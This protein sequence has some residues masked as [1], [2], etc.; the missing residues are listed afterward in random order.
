MLLCDA[1]YTHMAEGID[2]VLRTFARDWRGKKVLVKPNLLGAFLPERGV[3]TH[4]AVVNAVVKWLGAHGAKIVVGDNPGHIGY[5]INETVAL[6]S[7]I[8]A[9][10]DGCF[11]NI[12]TNPVKVSIGKAEVLVSKEVI[13]SDVYVSLPK[14][15]THI[16]T[17]FTGAIKN[18]YGL[19][20]GREKSRLHQMFPQL[21]DFA[22][23]V[24]AVYS[25]RPPD[26]VIMDAVVG[27]EGNGPNSKRL[28]DI[29]KIIG[30][31][32][33]VALDAVMCSMMGLNPKDQPL[34]QAAH[35]LGLGPILL[36]EINVKGDFNQIM[37]FQ[38]PVTYRSANT[39]QQY[40]VDRLLGRGRI[41]FDYNKC[42]SCG[43][44]IKACPQQ[45]IRLIESSR[46]L[47]PVVDNSRC[48][49]CFC[50][51]EMC[52]YNAVSFTGLFAALQ[53]VHNALARTW[54]FKYIIR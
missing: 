2:A 43:M 24:A 27:M 20:V 12:A 23:I 21:Q 51:K 31:D 4:P 6:V 39:L 9:A 8:V 53:R 41:D 30:S 29:N 14:F 25:I 48:I 36:E 50:C 26:L 17:T 10:S 7:G 35:K 45:A 52:P 16:Y 28:R 15:K 42:V 18:S 40:L 46:Q 44:C 33:G 3:T 22:D 1:D 13:E 34:L 37:G 5:G 54:P 47:R 11:R 49:L 19:L 38:L 32:N